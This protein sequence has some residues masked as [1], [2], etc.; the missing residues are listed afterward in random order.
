M[1]GY[2]IGPDNDRI[3]LETCKAADLVICAWGTHGKR[4][5]DVRRLLQK[6]G[7]QLFHLGPL[8][9]DKTPKNPSRLADAT[10][11]QEWGDDELGG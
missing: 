2:P 8:N 4:G 10:P 1:E 7:V 3:V 9:Q 6:E 5:P 11:L